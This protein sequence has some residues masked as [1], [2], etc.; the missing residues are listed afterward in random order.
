M[1]R[2]R[3]LADVRF[4]WSLSRITRQSPTRTIPHLQCAAYARIDRRAGQEFDSRVREV[5]LLDIDGDYAARAKKIDAVTRRRVLVAPYGSGF[6]K[7]PDDRKSSPD[8]P[9]IEDV[10][11]DLGPS[12]RVG[13]AFVF[14]ISW[15][16]RADWPSIG[17]LQCSV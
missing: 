1:A 11:P 4:R 5:V 7:E 16:R 6:D 8:D 3:Q 13:E 9:E 10:L 14:A 2:K 17:L 12:Q 15:S